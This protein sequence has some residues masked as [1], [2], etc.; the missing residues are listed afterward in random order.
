MAIQTDPA[1]E[2]ADFCM[3]LR[4]PVG[5]SGAEYLA[6][7]FGI[8]A[9]ST[10]FFSAIFI[11]NKRIDTLDTLFQGM[12]LEEDLKRMASSQLGVVKQAF[13]Q[14]GLSNNWQNSIS[15]NLTDAQLFPIKMASGYLVKS[16]GYSVPDG[17]ELDS[18]IL[19]LNSLIEWLEQID[20]VDNDFIRSALIDGLKAAQIRITKVEW[21]GWL[22]A[23]DTMRE[24]ISAYLLVERGMPDVGVSPPYEAM[25]KRSGLFIKK[26]Y[27]SVKFTKEAVEAGD[28]LL[29]GYGAVALIGH[30][31]QIAGLLS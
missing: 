1:R 7:K 6:G 2:F 22:D 17:E 16:H 12:D 4:D 24:V 30:S 20:V 26:F 31:N 27:D 28:W 10:D 29:R 14:S 19:E 18:I 25:F 13:S 15:Q 8:P 23:F 11:I 5:T 9:W 21:Y 3:R